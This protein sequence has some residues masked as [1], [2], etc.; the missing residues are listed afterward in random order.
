MKYWKPFK[1][2]KLGKIRV[3]EIFHASQIWY[4]ARFYPIPDAMAIKLQQDFQDYINYPLKKSTISK[5]E[6]YKLKIDGGAKLINVKTKSQ[7]PK[8]KC[9]VDLAETEDLKV[10]LAVVTRLLGKQ[11]G[12]IEGTD[13]FFTKKHYI[14][15]LAKFKS[16]FYKD[17]LKAITALKLIKK[18]T[19]PR[20][21]HI[22]FNP[23]IQTVH[24]KTMRLNGF[25]TKK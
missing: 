20:S 7:A 19:D 4:A 21:E 24:G 14:S 5:D 15:K 23:A 1:L 17:A 13:L 25:C 16:P 11:P 9:L 6:M 12:H 8:V 22:F 2:S 3:I 18:I 10:Q